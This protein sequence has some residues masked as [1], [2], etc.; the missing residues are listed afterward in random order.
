MS[1]TEVAM[2]SHY[3]RQEICISETTSANMLPV[4]YTFVSLCA[5]SLSKLEGHVPL[6]VI[7]LRHLWDRQKANS[8]DKHTITL[9]KAEHSQNQY[10]QNSCCICR[11]APILCTFY[12]INSLIQHLY[13]FLPTMFIFFH[14]D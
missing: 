8:T 12:H 2:C 3:W 10:L 4:C 9:L 13:D 1:A 7:W 11:N 6:P 14:L 5:P